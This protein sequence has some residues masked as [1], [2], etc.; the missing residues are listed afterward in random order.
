MTGQSAGSLAGWHHLSY[1]Y[2][3]GQGGK[4]DPRPGEE[5]EG[6]PKSSREVGHLSALAAGP[7]QDPR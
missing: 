6:R 4:G 7:G 5:G 2:L 1:S 3:Q